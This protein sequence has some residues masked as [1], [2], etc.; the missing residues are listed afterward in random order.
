MHEF[1]TA[2]VDNNTTHTTVHFKYNYLFLVY[3]SIHPSNWLE[4]QINAWKNIYFFL[5]FFF[6]ISITNLP[7]RWCTDITNR[8]LDVTLYCRHFFRNFNG[9]FCCC[10]YFIVF[11]QFSDLLLLLWLKEVVFIKTKKHK[12][13]QTHTHK[14]AKENF[15]AERDSY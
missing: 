10:S 7:N 12:L 2:K 4:W 14:L 5:L 8:F 1:V 6:W 11:F 9:I 3:P 13:S 15:C